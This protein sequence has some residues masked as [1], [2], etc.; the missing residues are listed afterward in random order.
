M[1]NT[2][3]TQAM[4]RLFKLG[5]MLVSAFALT[6]CAEE[7]NP[8]VQEDVNVDGNIESIT[9][10]EEE[11]D[12]PFEV[13]ANFGESAETK[14]I[15]WGNATYWEGTDEISVYHKPKG[16]TTYTHN[17]NFAVADVNKGLFTG[18]LKAALGET[19]DW[20]F[21][22]P[23]LG[24]SS[25]SAPTLDKVPVT[26]GESEL[27]IQAGSK[28]H[29]VGEKSPMYGV[30]KEVEMDKSPD[31][32]MNHLAAV[33]ALKIANNTDGPID[34]N[35][36]VFKTKEVPLVGNFIADLTKINDEGKIQSPFR[37]E[38]DE[39]INGNNK[40]NDVISP[41]THS[42]N[43]ST[44]VTISCPGTQI[45]ANGYETFYFAVCPNVH[46][47]NTFTILINGSEKVSQPESDVVFEP[48]KVTTLR[49]EISQPGV[50]QTNYPN[51]LGLQW[52][53]KL[54]KQGENPY[55]DI[56]TIYDNGAPLEKITNSNIP[57]A[58]GK[59][60]INN[61]EDV[62]V[63]K[64]GAGNEATI[65]IEGT[66]KEMVEA[67]PVGFYASRL[68]ALPTAMTL[69]KLDLL[70]PTGYTSK[71][72]FQGDDYSKLEGR[73]TL[74]SKFGTM[75]TAAKSLLE[76]ADI[77]MPD[78]DLS[79]GITLDLIK[80]IGISEDRLVFNGMISNMGFDDQN[81]ENSNVLVIDEERTYKCMSREPGGNVELY[82]QKFGDKATIEGFIDIF[83]QPYK[84][85]R[86]EWSA[87]A[88]ATGE[89][90]YEKVKSL[91]TAML[92]SKGLSEG[93]ASTATGILIKV[94][95]S[96]YKVF[97]YH[98]R[99]MVATIEISTRPFD[100]SKDPY[101]PIVFW[102][103]NYTPQ[104]TTSNN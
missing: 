47:I 37:E 101:N 61:L 67:L 41:F 56:V 75:I 31:I 62:D 16:A 77:T 1:L 55:H 18:F 6:N 11:V 102:G 68:N 44:S 71:G 4:K 13:F 91:M 69:K 50:L 66:L 72:W 80:S 48:G 36:V 12:I 49:L 52:Y 45:Q 82:L 96:D 20:Y 40:K 58:S 54:A 9:P 100:K 39:D 7:I 86:I 74:H 79:D 59:I 28:K 92:V 83:T 30:L 35:E 78:I 63:Y 24:D 85:G 70:L 73:Q 89:A 26:I 5:L 60:T 64:I 42:G 95:Y 97:M 87:A 23:Y 88:K 2:L 65:K 14:T 103:F 93:L 57:K 3:K 104:T 22:Y 27:P 17:S 98:M 29:I 38:G 53:D 21:F 19:N 51:A 76:L 15:N 8:P 99:D 33:V 32:L 25:G 43:K 46:K 90:I 94:Y 84:D 34:I 10:P 81:I